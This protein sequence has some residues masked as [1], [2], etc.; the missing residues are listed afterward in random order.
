MGTQISFQQAYFKKR[1]R[2]V[3][4]MRATL[5]RLLALAVIRRTAPTAQLS[6]MS[7]SQRRILW[8]SYLFLITEKEGFEPSRRLPD[9]H[10]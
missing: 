10:P 7:P 4:E 9:L 1:N 8:G 2:V 5:F 6:Q 3:R